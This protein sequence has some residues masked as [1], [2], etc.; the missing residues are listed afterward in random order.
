MRLG[1][2]LKI[3]QT[4]KLVMTQELIQA[5]KILQLNTQELQGLVSEELMTNPVLEFSESGE[6]SFEDSGEERREPDDSAYADELTPGLRGS[7]ARDRNEHELS[8]FDRMEELKQSSRY[9]DI[10]YRQWEYQGSKGLEPGERASQ[11]D[12]SLRSELLRQLDF[13][14][15]DKNK[16]PY[17]EYIIESLDRNGYLQDS[18]KELSEELS[19]PLALV[20]ELI[21]L[22]KTMEP[23]GVGAASLSECLELQLSDMPEGE[24]KETALA[25]VRSHLSELAENRLP[26]LSRELGCELTRVQEAVDIIKKL[27]PKPG[28]GFSREANTRYIVPDVFLEKNGSEYTVS[29]N[30][31][32]IPHLIISP[33]YRNLLLKA[34]KDEELSEY[35]SG[36]MEAA[37][38]LI[39]SIEQRKNTILNIAAAIVRC[40][41]DFFDKGEK[42]LK[43]LTLRYIAEETGVH[44]STVSRSVN[45]KYIETP[46]GVYEL[47]FFFGG[48]V[49]DSLG[50]AKSSK[51]I[52]AEIKEMVENEDA[53]RPLSDQYMADR[54]SAEGIDISRRTVA[55][56]RDEM[57]I[58]SSSKR[59]RY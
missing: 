41:K 21:A 58:L 54:L 39:K 52:K 34:E 27:E 43:P 17:A 50:D 15:L 13:A 24:L 56:Y 37:L 14:L 29:V 4:Q 35:L 6:G 10:S 16:K 53:R 59:K 28:R 47:K 25:I 30:E 11:E 26:R 5:I 57:G 44:E 2:D 38:W 46:R 3:E 19:I 22:I 49:R 9:D 20:E 45:G 33:Y 12:K 36:K 42:Y 40:Q 18:P 1:F 55:K 51:S 48:G 7:K 31:A 8:D 23:K 32:G